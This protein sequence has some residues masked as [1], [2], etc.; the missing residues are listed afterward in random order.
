MKT[1]NRKPGLILLL[2]LLWFDLST[3]GVEAQ[4]FI[5]NRDF[6]NLGSPEPYLNYGR[7]PY[8]PY[9]TI[10][11]SRNR[12]DRL[13]G[14]LFRGFDVFRW[15]ISRPGV[16]NISNRADQYGGWFNNVVILNDSYRGW[17]FGLTMGEDIRM[18][19]TDLTV[20]DPR[21]FG[22]LFDGASSD[23]RFTLLLRQGG[24][25]HNVGRFSKFQQTTER[26]PVLAFGGHWETKLGDILKVGATYF[27]Q[28]MVDTH[29]EDGSFFRGDMP[30][31]M[32]PPSKITVAVEDDS[33]EDGGTPA[34]VYGVDI[35]ITG[36]SQGQPFRITSI[37]TD[38]DYNSALEAGAP[39]GGTPGEDGAQVVQGSGDRVLYHFTMPEIVLPSA[40]EYVAESN[41][42]FRGLTIEA[43]RF[44]ADV[45]GDYRIGV[46][47]EHLFFDEKAH[48]KNV[49]RLAEGDDR[50]E[51]G[52]S[53]F[54][55]PFTGLKGDDSLLSPSE[56]V[57]AGHEGVFK[58]WPLDPPDATLAA[59]QFKDYKWDQYP[60]QVY[61]TVLRSEGRN[62]NRQQVTFSY[63]L[64][65]GQALYGMNGE[66][67]LKG[68]T[69]NGEFVVNPQSFIFPIGSNAGRRH[70]KRSW[71]YFVNATKDVKSL[72]LGGEL[73][74]LD[75]DYS[76]NYD[77]FR[78]GIPFFTDRGIQGPEMEEFFVMHDN[79]DNDQWPDDFLQERLEADKVDGGIFP[80]LDENMDLV[81]D[82]DQNLNGQPDW[83]EPILFYD[84]EPPEFTYGIDFNNN[85]VVDYRE[86]DRLPDYPY[87]RDRKGW[88]TFVLRDGLGSFGNWISLGTYRMDAAAEGS[89]ANAIYGRYEYGYLS[90]FLGNLKLNADV[91]WV[92][93]D[94]RDDVYIWRDLSDERILSP[95]PQYTG[96]RIEEWD[97]NS[98]W[99]P[100]P[101]DPLKMRNSFVSTLFFE[102]RYKQVTGLNVI[103]NVQW[104]RNS[105]REDE[106]EDGSIQD[107]DV[108]S[109][110]TMVN[111]VDY[112]IRLGD[113]SIRPMFKHLLLRRHSQAEEVDGNGSQESF[114]IYSPILRT[115]LL[116]TSK[117]D[118]Q[119][120][121]Q[122]FPF[123]KYRRND[124]VDDLE[125]FKEW[126]FL[127]MMSNRSD[128]YGFNLG[129]QFG[130]MKT[131]REYDAQSR[132]IDDRDN[133]RIFLD[134]VAG[135]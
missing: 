66:L 90:P 79:D 81:P 88:H 129:S 5:R 26:S 61:Y 51:E 127:V 110:T 132:K 31:N 94:I 65:T 22:V 126:T 82:S 115:K 23:N 29:N 6:L 133:S 103:N 42:S 1:T 25:I 52:G 36:T 63:G 30:H 38:P 134:I 17:D 131:S 71:A 69:V 114:S 118:L 7:E 113:L 46:R 8:E 3:T 77:S 59:I 41:Y 14:Y 84:A 67:T 83:T 60:G 24:F 15:E 4:T 19:L 111:K 122:G 10:T 123:W 9:P 45:A 12:Y 80:G 40:E 125:S 18:K 121:F 109:L 37:D 89:K 119:V 100:P 101:P 78:G 50:Y 73:F 43:I 32:L 44:V 104:L 128:Q 70:S 107:Q 55:N 47:Q 11:N 74:N 54:V 117:S 64:P 72:E 87:P 92:E 75:A 108:L 106:F 99:L 85:G 53:R 48:Q 34:V 33:P 28:R 20:K 13:G 76:G 49:E 21:Y 112:T 56:A 16:S 93:D 27:N 97:L 62:T 39:T 2:P 135:W 116:L 105:Q 57:E 96:D 95:F 120:A 130:W 68:F 102:S 35:I 91:K 58:S 124:R 98:Q 86:N